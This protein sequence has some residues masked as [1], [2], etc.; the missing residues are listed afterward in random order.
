MGGSR[1]NDAEDFETRARGY[2][3]QARRSRWWCSAR[4]SCATLQ[5]TPVE[6]PARLVESLAWDRLG[7]RVK[8]TR[9][10]MAIAS[11]RPGSVAPEAGLE[12]GDV[13]LRVNNQPIANSEGFREAL[14]TARGDVASCC[15]YAGGGMGITHHPAL[16]GPTPLA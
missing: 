9:G 14:L 2:P 5:V 8:E 6:F 12:P 3:A 1:I 11:V 4:A 16:P 10:A 15:S 13:I 7:L